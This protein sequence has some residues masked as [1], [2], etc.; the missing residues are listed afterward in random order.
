MIWL[1]ILLETVKLVDWD[2]RQGGS[3]QY[4]DVLRQVLK[5]DL[6]WYF[7]KTVKYMH[8]TEIK[9][10]STNQPKSPFQRVH[11]TRSPD[12]HLKVQQRPVIM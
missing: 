1:Q 11:A 2:L 3:T 10:V 8:T 7:G 6:M 4:L 12:K 5:S 9:K